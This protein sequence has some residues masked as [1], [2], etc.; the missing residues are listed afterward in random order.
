[1][2]LFSATKI[3][4]AAML[5]FLLAGASAR[6]G[7]LKLESQLVVGS[8]DTKPQDAG[9]KPVAPDI[10]RKLEKL[11]LKWAHYYVV[12]DKKFSAGGNVKKIS[13]SKDCQISVKNLGN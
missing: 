2:K 12:N 10:E 8:N 7:D 4:C 1:M 11:P 3:V 5:F 6:A 13:L 9:L